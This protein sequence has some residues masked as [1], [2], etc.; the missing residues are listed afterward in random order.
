MQTQRLTEKLT[1]AKG[2]LKEANQQ[3]GSSTQ[4]ILIFKEEVASSNTQV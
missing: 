4:I 3:Q 2:N 1:A